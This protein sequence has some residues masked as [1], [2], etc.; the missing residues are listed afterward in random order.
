[1]EHYDFPIYHVPNGLNHFINQF[2]QAKFGMFTC[3]DLTFQVGKTRFD[4]ELINYWIKKD[5]D[6]IFTWYLAIAYAITASKIPIE[7]FEPYRRSYKESK[8]F[9]QYLTKNPNHLSELNELVQNIESDGFYFKNQ[10]D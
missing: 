6:R 2:Y 8:L 10:R 5:K 7:E 1:M 9:R 4:T 3:H